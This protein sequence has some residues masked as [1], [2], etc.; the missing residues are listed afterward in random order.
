MSTKKQVIWRKMFY[1]EFPASIWRLFKTV[2]NFPGPW[3]HW[4]WY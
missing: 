3:R 4:I 2:W 1:W